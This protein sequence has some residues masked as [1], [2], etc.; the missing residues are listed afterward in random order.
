MFFSEIDPFLELEYQNSID[1]SYEKI[2][3]G[4]GADSVVPVQTKPAPLPVINHESCF[5]IDFCRSKLTSFS[6]SSQSLSH[7]VSTK[8][9]LIKAQKNYIYKRLCN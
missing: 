8:T 5:D 7:S 2:H 3:G 9:C 4:A 1:A 6:Y